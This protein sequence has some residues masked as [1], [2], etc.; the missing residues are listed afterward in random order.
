[1]ASVAG[2]TMTSATIENPPSDV[3]FRADRENSFSKTRTP[4]PVPAGN[5]GESSD[6]RAYN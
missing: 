6:K 3:G 4:V 1:M 2:E 5:P